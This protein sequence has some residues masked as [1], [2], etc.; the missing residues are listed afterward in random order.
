[1]PD[2]LA[3]A[4]LLRFFT[5]KLPQTSSKKESKTESQENKSREKF[6]F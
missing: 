5:N 6:Q 4:D 3:T 1:M 2:V